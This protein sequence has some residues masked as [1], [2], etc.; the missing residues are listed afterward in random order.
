MDARRR[1]QGNKVLVRLGRGREVQ[2]KAGVPRR[3]MIEPGFYM[4]TGE[5]E[6]KDGS[7]FWALLE[8]DEDTSGV[9]CGTGIFL[10]DGRVLFQ[11]DPGFE[12]ALEGLGVT[13]HPY[14]YKYFGGAF[15]D[16]HIGAD[17]WSLLSTGGGA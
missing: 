6:L 8:I 2:F 10:P 15:Q 7:R 16:R 5:V 1:T 4:R 13:A 9:H 14:K 11:G 12:D 17:G 3:F